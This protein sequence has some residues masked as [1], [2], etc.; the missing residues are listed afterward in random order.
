MP[1]QTKICR[2]CGKTYESC[3]SIKTGSGVFNWREMCCSPECGQIYFQRVE[4]S[5]N[6]APKAKGKKVHSRRETAVKTDSVAVETVSINEQEDPQF[7]TAE[8]N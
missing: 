1:K 8:E 6:P 3:R 2:V 7:D 4:D 5:R